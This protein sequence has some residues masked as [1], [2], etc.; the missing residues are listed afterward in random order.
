MNRRPPSTETCPRPATAIL[1]NGADHHARQ[2]HLEDA[3]HAIAQCALPVR[4]RA[5]SLSDAAHAVH[6]VARESLPRIAGELRDS[7]GYT[8]TL[9]GTLATRAHQK[10][11]NAQVERALVRDAEPWCAMLPGGGDA[12]TRA[13]LRSAWRTLLTAHPHDTLC[14]TSI[15][16]VARAMDERLR[17][18][19]DEAEAIRDAAI[20]VLIG[21]DAAGARVSPERWKDVVVVRN[22]A[23][24]TRGGIV[25]LTL[26]AK[27]ADVSVG[28]G[29]ASRQGARR[30]PPAFR[31]DGMRIQ[32]LDRKERASFHDAIRIGIRDR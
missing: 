30:R 31:I 21:H 14:G 23:A 24:R 12:T 15:D 27:V 13:L 11:H 9:G 2:P 1:L 5:S 22:A 7:Y 17:A 32:V 20:G 8:W 26:R 4:V 18:A 28:P 3:L 29:S 10:R 6:S 16:A 25:E 19:A